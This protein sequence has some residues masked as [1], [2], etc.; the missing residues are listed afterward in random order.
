MMLNRL[1]Y[2]PEPE[3]FRH[4][5]LITAGRPAHRKWDAFRCRHPEMEPAHRAKLFAPFDALTGFTEMLDESGAET[6]RQQ[7]GR[8]V[9]C[10]CF[11]D[12]A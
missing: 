7:E 1:G 11:D 4:H 9:Y 2:M 6:G 3:G 5:N 10:P 12:C 8:M